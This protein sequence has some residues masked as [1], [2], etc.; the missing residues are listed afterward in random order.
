[1]PAPDGES[2]T[3]PR[4]TLYVRLRL[5]II[6]VR[7]PDITGGEGRIT[8]RIGRTEERYNIAVLFSG[9]FETNVGHI[10]TT[11]DSNFPS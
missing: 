4:L 8:I 5:Y 11:T 3:T 6:D 1:M 2:V 7:M 10:L 9:I